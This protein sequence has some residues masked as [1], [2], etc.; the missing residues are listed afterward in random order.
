MK[1]YQVNCDLF[2]IIITVTVTNV[3]I[4]II[5][6]IIMRNISPQPLEY[7]QPTLKLKLS[8]KQ[9]LRSETTY[10]ESRTNMVI[11]T[12]ALSVLS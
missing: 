8:Q 4:L 6:N 7:I 12:D 1:A 10:S 2:I 5:I 3:T 11:F 9:Q